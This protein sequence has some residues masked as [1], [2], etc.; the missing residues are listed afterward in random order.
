MDSFSL[1]D[2]HVF[3]QIADTAPR[4]VAAYFMCLNNVDSY[5]RVSFSKEYITAVKGHSWIKFKNDLKALAALS[6]LNFY[7]ESN[8]VLIEMLQ[9]EGVYEYRHEL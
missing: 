6:I 2:K 4:A 3:L 5:G 7:E 1:A 9:P 8:Q